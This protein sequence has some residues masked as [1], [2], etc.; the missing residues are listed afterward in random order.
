MFRTSYLFSIFTDT[1]RKP[2]KI[3]CAE[4]V[5]LHLNH[6]LTASSASDSACSEQLPDYY[7]SQEVGNYMKKWE[8]WKWSCIALAAVMVLAVGGCGGSTGQKA[9]GTAAEQTVQDTADVSPADQ[10]TSDTAALPSNSE[11]AMEAS[12]DTPE[13]Q[14]IAG[15]SVLPS[16]GQMARDAL[17][18]AEV[19]SA[20]EDAQIPATAEAAACEPV[21]L[22]AEE[23]T[24]SL[25]ADMPLAFTFS[26]GAGG[27]STDIFLQEDGTFSGAYYD[28]DMGSAD[29]DYPNGT[30]YYC[31]FGGK[32]DIV[33]KLDAYSYTLKLASLEKEKGKEYIED[34][35]RYVPSEPYGMERGKNYILYLPDTPL[36]GLSEEFLMWWPGRYDM[37]EQERTTLGYYG[38]YN[39]DMQYGFFGEIQ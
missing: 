38:L 35:I 25:P 19:E 16:A 10:E 5:C 18:E 7:N 6:V 36:E 29:N 21:N 13:N 24:L 12:D 11:N 2:M 17:S 15:P 8:M 37:Q 31:N 3:D 28:S 9:E 26:S 30:V 4:R 22:E 34:G 39:T 27:W 14:E 33:Q 32:L 20:K 23:D 1:I